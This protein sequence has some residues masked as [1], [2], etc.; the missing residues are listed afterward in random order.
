MESCDV[1]VVIPCWRASGTISRAL[2]SVAA[3]TLRP[4]EVILVDDGGDAAEALALR[5]AMAAFPGGWAKLLR[6]PKNSGPGLARNAGWGVATGAWVAFLDSDDAWHPEKLR[7]QMAAISYWPTAT[8]CGHCS[9]LWSESTCAKEVAPLSPRDISK[10]TFW[11]M[12]IKNRLPTRTVMLKSDVPFRFQARYVAED[13]LLWLELLLAG[14]ECIVFQRQVAYCFREEYSE[15]GLSGQ[16][17]RHEVRELS[18]WRYLLAHGNISIHVWLIASTWSLV[19]YIRRLF[20]ISLR[21]LISGLQIL[22]ARD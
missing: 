18:A 21:R 16:L 19:K 6:L 7:M 22:R 15:G 4:K 5:D 10:V 9:T 1:S 8:V 13:Y 11:Q 2:E 17:F 3:Q 14:H 20:L 12:L